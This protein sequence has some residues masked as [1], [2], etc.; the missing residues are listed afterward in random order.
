MMGRG[1]ILLV[2]VVIALLVFVVPGA[3]WIVAKVSGKGK[4]KAR[5]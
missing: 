3:L 2:A 5:R 1:E 4:R